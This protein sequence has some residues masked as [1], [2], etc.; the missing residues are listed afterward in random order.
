MSDR[1]TYFSVS[2]FSLFRAAKNL[3]LKSLSS[4][5]MTAAFV[6]VCKPWQKDYTLVKKVLHCVHDESLILSEPWN[7]NRCRNITRVRPKECKLNI[8]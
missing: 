1:M 7:K 5:V 6:D 3:Y 8:V 4:T 2:I